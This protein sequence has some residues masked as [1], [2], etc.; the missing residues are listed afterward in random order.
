M[1]Q[2]A[3]KQRVAYFVRP[4]V[5]EKFLYNLLLKVQEEM[6]QRGQDSPVGLLNNGATLQGVVL[7]F[8]DR[9]AGHEVSQ[10]S[11]KE[12]LPF[13]VYSGYTRGSATHA[14]AIAKSAVEA[15]SLS[16]ILT[17]MDQTS[18][19][20]GFR[21]SNRYDHPAR[22]RIKEWMEAEFFRLIKEEMADI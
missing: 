6:N 14:L 4:T 9:V 8:K 2:F 21:W 19:Y 22:L 15:K 7:L 12:A 11:W 20:F 10:A 5:Q 13:N 1:T 17:I 3:T 18:D 16:E